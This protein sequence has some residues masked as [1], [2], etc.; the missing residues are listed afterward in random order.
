VILKGLLSGRSG[1]CPQFCLPWGTVLPYIRYTHCERL[2]GTALRECLDWVIPPN[3][4]HQVSTIFDQP[5]RS[6][7]SFP[8]LVVPLLVIVRHDPPLTV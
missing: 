1:E 6:I 7:N 5:S 3:E 8:T 4:R 2:I